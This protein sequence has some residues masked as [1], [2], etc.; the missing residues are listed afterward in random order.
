MQLRWMAG[1]SFALMT[2]LAASLA[3]YALSVAG[4][5]PMPRPFGT[6][7]WDYECGFTVNSVSR[8]KQLGSGPTAVRA[9]GEFYVVN[10]T[11]VCPFGERYRWSPGSA[12]VGFNRGRAMAHPDLRAQN[13]LDGIARRSS[14]AH[15]VLGAREAQRLVFDLPEDA[16]Q[17]ALF[18]R[19]TLGWGAFFDNAEELRLYTPHRFNLRYD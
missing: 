10:A 7:L 18:F 14:S 13:V 4:R 11:V 9:N 1:L 12:F 5:P 6:I 8:H 19:D 2:F 16:A 3:L 17:P 15:V